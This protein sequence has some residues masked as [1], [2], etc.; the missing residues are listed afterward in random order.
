MKF[1]SGELDSGCTREEKTRVKLDQLRK[2]PVNDAS[3]TRQKKL[4]IHLILPGPEKCHRNQRKF[5][6]IILSY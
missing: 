4:I 5:K 2:S 3:S 1:K 6:V